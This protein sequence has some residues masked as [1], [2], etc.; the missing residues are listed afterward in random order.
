MCVLFSATH[1]ERTTALLLVGSYAK[2][3]RS[4]DYPWAPAPEDREREIEETEARWGSPD[5]LRALAPSKAN[6]EAF[7]RWVGRYLRQ[8]AS[9]KAAAAMLRMNTQIDVRDILPAIRVPTVL[10]YRTDDADVH[11]DEGRYIAGRIPGARFVELPGGDHTMWTGDASAILDEIEEFLTGVR[12]GPEPDRVLATILFTDVVGSTELATR[13]GDRAWRDLLARH[14]EAVRREL[15]R[16]R[17]R[18]WT[19]PATGSSRRSTAGQGDPLRGRGGRVGPGLGMEIRAG[20]TPARSRSPTA[21]SAGSP[22]TSARASRPRGPG[23]VL[24]SRT[25]ADLV[26]GRASSLAERGRTRAEGRLGHLAGVRGRVGVRHSASSRGRVRFPRPDV[27]GPGRDRRGPQRGQGQRVPRRA[28]ARGRSRAHRGGAPGPRRGRRGAGSSIPQQRYER[29]GAEI[30]G[31][32]AEVWSSSDMIMKVKE[33][34]A[35][36]FEHLREGQILFTY[37]HLAASREL[38]QAL[39]ERKVAAVAYETVQLPDGR[40][41][42]LA[43]MSEIAGRMAP[44]VAAHLLEKEYGGR[45]ILMG[46]VSGVRPAK[47]FVLGAGMA[48]SNAAWIAAG[49]EAEVIVVDTNLDRLR[50]IDQ[51]HKGR[52]IT[53]ASDRLT[54][55]QRVREADIV[56]GSVLVPGAKAPKLVTAEMIRSMR[57]GAVAIDIA[58]DQGGCMETSHMTTHS[59]PTYVVDGVVHYCVGNMPGAVPNTSTYALTNVTLPYAIDVANRGLEDAVRAN[60]ALALGVN[61]YAGEVTNPGVAEAHGLGLAPLPTVIDGLG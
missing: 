12:R 56:I 53:L 37:L 57:E 15:E 47:V 35:S 61:A 9:P 43:P 41:P 45:G 3:I 27:G 46:G 52:I 26:A 28:D 31:T 1:P 6:D 42:L 40:L 58:I 22:S 8:S 59:D 29:A 21:S 54:L 51:I 32:A 19:P 23:E 50:F 55:E 25:V 13:L 48:G 4:D 5:M 49:M 33:P 39:A 20:C 60:P 34:V 30:V 44:H 10:I 16:W 7:E 2:R 17:G 24:V 11:P 38:T 14:H 36:E 18:R